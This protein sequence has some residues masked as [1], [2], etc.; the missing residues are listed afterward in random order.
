M[1][2]ECEKCGKLFNRK[3]NL[4]AHYNRKFKCNN[5]GIRVVNN[6]VNNESEILPIGSNTTN[7]SQNT[8][9]LS[10][11]TTNLSQ[12][13]EKIFQC[14]KCLKMFSRNNVLQ[15]H[16][17]NNCKGSSTKKQLKINKINSSK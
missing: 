15:N 8:T 5:N 11:N 13:N 4:E 2:Y 9:N 12:N 10:Q 3:Y 7:L 16:I 14:G 1:N 6:V 17:K